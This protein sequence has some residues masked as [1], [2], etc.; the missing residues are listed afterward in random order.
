MAYSLTMIV[1]LTHWVAALYP[2]SLFKSSGI[3]QSKIIKQK[4]K[5]WDNGKIHITVNLNIVKCNHEYGLFALELCIG[6]RNWNSMYH[7]CHRRTSWGRGHQNLGQSLS[8]LWA[9]TMTKLNY[10]EEIS[11]GKNFSY[12][13]KYYREYQFFWKSVKY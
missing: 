9:Q 2:K 7:C 4:Q 1:W 13:G 12:V 8:I 10:W 11:L 5:T 3:R 6:V